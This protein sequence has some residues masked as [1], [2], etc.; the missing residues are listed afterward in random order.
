MLLVFDHDLGGGAGVYR[1]RLVASRLSEGQGC[2]VVQW[3]PDRGAYALTL[4]GEAGEVVES[5]AEA[6]LW[7]R[8]ASLD[9]GECVV[10]NV[11]SYPAPL[12][13]LARLREFV[14]GRGARLTMLLHDY[15]A[16]CPSWT[17][18]DERGSFCGIPGDL[19][20]CEA[21][22]RAN[23]IHFKDELAVESVAEW[24]AAWGEL[25]RAAD[26]VRCFSGSSR[27]LLLRAYPGLRRVTVV[28]HR[29]D[30]VRN[31]RVAYDVHGPIRVGVVGELWP[32]KGSEVVIALA[33]EIR[34]SAADVAVVV[35][36]TLA[37]DVGEGAVTITGPYAPAELPGLLER[38]GVN[39]ALFPSICPETFSYVCEE[40]MQMGL[41]VIAFD[42]GAPAERLRHYPLGRVVPLAGPAAL[43]RDIV[44]FVADLRGSSA[45]S[46][47][48]RNG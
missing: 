45:P 37:G 17:L 8:L 5:L 18:L 27:E 34:R 10:N 3:S 11:V 44:G 16:V 2:A 9:V 33:A 30:H 31:R 43:L 26:E 48:S 47:A 42:L 4:H 19:A 38:Q 28:L 7:R 29:L 46:Q 20:R 24:R 41:P 32:H 36:G 14:A 15:H 12:R 1:R 35:V 6:A 22:F 21:C 25:L 40:L 13:L 23:P 39:V